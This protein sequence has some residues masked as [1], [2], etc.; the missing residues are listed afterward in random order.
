MLVL[1]EAG[2]R[3]VAASIQAE[4]AR[5]VHEA[6]IESLTARVQGLTV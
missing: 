3:E 2:A 4:F 5:M 6:S 1:Q